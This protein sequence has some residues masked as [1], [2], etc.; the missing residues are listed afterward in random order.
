MA[1]V[2]RPIREAERLSHVVLKR[3]RWAAPAQVTGVCGDEERAW[4]EREHILYF[5]LHV[6]L[7]YSFTNK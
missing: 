3:S 2:G 1:R 6:Q 5:V 7:G 4:G